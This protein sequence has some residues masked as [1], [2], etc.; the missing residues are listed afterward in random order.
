MKKMMGQMKDP[1]FMKRM[2][3]MKNMP[4]DAQDAV[5]MRSR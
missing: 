1:R 5:L 2:A 4:G 3:A